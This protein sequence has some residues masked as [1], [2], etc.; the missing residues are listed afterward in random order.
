MLF[1]PLMLLVFQTVFLVL[2]F[3]NMAF[4]MKGNYPVHEITMIVAVAVELV[5]IVGFSAGAIITWESMEPLMNPF[6][7]LPVFLSHSAR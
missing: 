1:D 5:A 6:S 7:T 4:R 2:L 3:V